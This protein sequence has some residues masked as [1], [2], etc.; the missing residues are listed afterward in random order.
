MFFNAIATLS[1]QSVVAVDAMTFFEVTIARF[2][3]D[4][5][6]ILLRNTF[7][8]PGRVSV[9]TLLTLTSNSFSTASLICGFVACFA[10]LKVTLLCSDAMVAFSVITGAMMTS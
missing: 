9:L 8:L 6:P 10:T 2:T 1:L 4:C 3:S 7:I 5:C